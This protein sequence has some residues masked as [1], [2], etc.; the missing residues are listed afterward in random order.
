MSNE[1]LVSEIQQGVN[2][3]NNME[4]LYTQNKRLIYS[5]IKRYRYACQSDY[6]STSII[7]M[8][9]LMHEAYFGLIKAVESYDSSQ[10]IL[11]MSYAPYWIRQ[12]IK[13]YLDNCGQTIRVPVHKQQKV[14]NYNQT[15]SYYLQHFNR[16]PTTC[17]YARWLQ[18]SI[19]AIESLEKFMFQD[20]MKSLDAPIPGGE[21][22][23][24]FI[25][26]TVASDIDLEN[27]I[28][29]K[30]VKEQ[31]KDELWKIVSEVLKDDKM[32]EVIRYRFIDKLTLE[33]VGQRIGIT[34]E[35][36][37]QYESKAL[38]RLRSNSRTKQLG[39]T[40]GFGEDRALVDIGS[41]KYKI[42]QGYINWLCDKEIK[43]AVR[44]GWIKEERA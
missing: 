13:R 23:D 34:R 40:L 10:D 2:V 5:I 39:N 41:I 21:D 16:Q 20:H 3:K 22:E 11:F 25:V 42:E 4:Q 30:V 37:R 8:D 18:V 27:D 35:M 14:Y 24:I 26:D 43:Y 32:V 36:V 6:N 1:E 7:E 28:V 33:E 31:T 38:R 29:D 44:M 15:T 17:E 12:V 19:K 9:E